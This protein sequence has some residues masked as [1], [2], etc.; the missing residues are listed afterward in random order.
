[1][2]MNQ[3]LLLVIAIFIARCSTLADAERSI[4]VDTLATDSITES[5]TVG[6]RYLKG[7][8][9]ATA[10][11]TVDEERIGATTPNFGMLKGL[12]KLPK[13]E[14]LSK[15]PVIKQ[16]IAAKKKFGTKIVDSYLKRERKR[17]ESNPQNFM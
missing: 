7:I 13:F 11:D 4:Q 9:T 5:A 16:L 6:H 1:M 2:R 14:S 10:L 3:L 17:Y 12:F 8:K 15:L